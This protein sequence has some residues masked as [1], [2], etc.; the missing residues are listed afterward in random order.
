MWQQQQ[1]ERKGDRNREGELQKR[2]EK[3]E[4]KERKRVRRKRKIRKM[5]R[6]IIEGK[7]SEREIR[8][9]LTELHWE[10]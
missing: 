2:R 1:G 7:K 3:R 6:I 9:R 8:K 4:R 5:K 10:K